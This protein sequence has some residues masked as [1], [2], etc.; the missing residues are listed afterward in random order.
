MLVRAT[1]PVR[2]MEAYAAFDASETAA[3]ASGGEGH[4]V[5]SSSGKREFSEVWTEEL[6]NFTFSAA[7]IAATID[8]RESRGQRPRC[9]LKT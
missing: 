6:E 4:L 7:T 3:E 5:V 1:I 8:C 9:Q 2:S